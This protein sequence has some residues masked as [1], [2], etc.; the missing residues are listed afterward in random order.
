MYIIEKYCVRKISLNGDVTTLAGSFGI[1]GDVDGIGTAVKFSSWSKTITYHNNYLYIADNGNKKIKKLNLSNNEVTTIITISNHP[2]DVE[3]IGSKLYVSYNDSKIYRYDLDGSN[4]EHFAGNGEGN[5][6]G[7]LLTSKFD[8]PYRISHHNGDI[9]I[10]ERD[11]H[12][13]KIIKGVGNN[14]EY[15]KKQKWNNFIKYE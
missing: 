2:Q 8:F 15:A 13:V 14:I 9:F 7:D 6:T 4:E 10:G 12:C 1:S 5:Q 3:V 11:N